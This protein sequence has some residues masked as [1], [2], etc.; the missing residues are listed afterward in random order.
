[1]VLY[2]GINGHQVE[3]DGLFFFKIPSWRWGE[4]D[5]EAVRVTNDQIH[6]IKI[7]KDYYKH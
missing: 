5:M 7:L 1:M 4:V 3:L 6:Y 2:P